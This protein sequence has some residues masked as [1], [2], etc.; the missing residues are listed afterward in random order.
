[1]LLPSKCSIADSSS[2][3]PPHRTTQRC[4]KDCRKFSQGFF[5]APEDFF[6]YKKLGSASNLA[7]LFLIASMHRQLLH[8]GLAQIEGNLK[9]VVVWEMVTSVARRSWLY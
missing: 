2:L 7:Q 1:M 4:C 5:R 8:T 6:C 3:K 9:S